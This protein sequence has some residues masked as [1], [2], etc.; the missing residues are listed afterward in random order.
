MPGEGLVSTSCS[1]GLGERRGC[2]AFA[3]HD[4]IVQLCHS[5]NGY[6]P[7]S[8]KRNP[9]PRHCPLRPALTHDPLLDPVPDRPVPDSPARSAPCRVH[10]GYRARRSATPG[11]LPGRAI[12]PAVAGLPRSAHGTVRC[13]ERG[14]AGAGSRASREPQAWHG[15]APPAPRR[16]RSRHAAART[17]RAPG[18][19]APGYGGSQPAASGVNSRA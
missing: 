18:L 16:C 9:S 3:R 8:G 17:V 2:R 15:T 11:R 4:G 19:R 7:L 12:A 13:R 6:C 1:A 14:Q 10:R 5:S